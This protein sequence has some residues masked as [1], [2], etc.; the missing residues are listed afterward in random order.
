MTE[1]LL[2]LP[3]NAVANLPVFGDDKPALAPMNE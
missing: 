2:P 1:F 3:L